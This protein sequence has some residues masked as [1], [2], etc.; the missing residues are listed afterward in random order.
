MLLVRVFLQIGRPSFFTCSQQC[1][2][3]D[4][5]NKTARERKNTAKNSLQAMFGGSLVQLTVFIFAFGFG[6]LGALTGIVGF[7]TTSPHMGGGGR[8]P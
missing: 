2:S 5:Y 7:N 8:G 4:E 1:Q 6:A 3:T